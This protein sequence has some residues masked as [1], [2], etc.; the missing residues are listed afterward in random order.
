MSLTTPKFR[1][2]EFKQ[3]LTALKEVF[4][5]HSLGIVLLDALERK[6]AEQIVQK[7]AAPGVLPRISDVPKQA[8]CGHI[9]GWFFASEDVAY[10]TMKELDRACQKERHIVA[11]IPEA[12]APERVGS[13]RAIA[14]KRER[15]KFV[16]A[17]SRDDRGAVRKLAARIINEFF[18]E[19]ADIENARAIVRND[20]GSPRL[21]DVE[22]AKRIQAQAERLSEATNEVTDLQT[23][24]D[25]FEDERARLLAAIGAKEQEA[26]QAVEAREELDHELKR[27]RTAL[28]ELEAKQREAET[29]RASEREAR[30]IAEDLAQKV[31]RLEKLA[32]AA[33]SLSS[34]Q[35]E[36]EEQRRKNEELLRQVARTEQAQKR[37]REELDRER[38]RL[39]SELDEA[40]AELHRARK[41]IVELESPRPAVEPGEGAPERRTLILL[42]QANLAAGAALSFHRKVNFA[43]LYDR[44]REGGAADA[45]AFLVDNGG[46]AFDSFSATLK[47]TGWDLRIKKPKRFQDGSTKADWDMGI[48]VEAI[49]RVESWDRLILVSG[50]GDFAP[51]VRHF[52][53]R[54]KIVQVAAF[55]DG[56][57]T[58]LREAADK[59]L[60]L[61]T[62]ILE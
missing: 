34:A 57:A 22:L 9:T 52:R 51:L 28:A 30:A 44:L 6:S 25:R 38:Q 47:R 45:V 12:E 13:Y 61:D 19:V 32:G 43:L 3:A 58:E 40:R 49:E 39:R 35:A 17:L 55:A 2:A 5:A 15:A 53:R 29:A 7:N 16:W 59:V 37:E 60:I 33:E 26:R 27:M 1:S 21:E 48:A 42:D 8:L 14:L 62:G 31:R 23:R 24:V 20:S 18:Q 10:Q 4:D 56:L 54:G 41:H 11:S 36:L 50:D 46:S